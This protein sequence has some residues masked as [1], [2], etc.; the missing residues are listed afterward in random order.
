MLRFMVPP[1][2][3]APAVTPGPEFE[4]RPWAAL[5]DG[6]P[7]V[8]R[9]YSQCLP[10]FGDGA[11]R[12]LDAV[13]QQQVGERGIGQR[14]V[15]RLRGD[16]ALDHGLDRGRRAGPALGRLDVA[17]EEILELVEA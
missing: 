7:L 13:L 11:A 14:L 12:D 1:R 9:R 10:V 8:R 15:G 5:R 17:R 2:F 4:A 6:P 16:Q 3:D